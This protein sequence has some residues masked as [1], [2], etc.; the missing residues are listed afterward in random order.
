MI[1]TLTVDQ[2]SRYREKSTIA[3][4]AILVSLEARALE[5]RIVFTSSHVAVSPQVC[6]AY[7]QVTWWLG[8]EIA[9]YVA[10]G[11]EEIAT[12]MRRRAAPQEQ[13]ADTKE[14][15]L[16]VARVLDATKEDMCDTASEWDAV[17]KARQAYQ[18]A[19]EGRDALRAAWWEAL[20]ESLAVESCRRV[21][22]ALSAT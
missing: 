18:D 8:R 11:D 15:S 20:D 9:L 19:T 22:L 12:A 17:V 14:L 4:R 7:A 16:Y 1:P 5:E 21:L 10:L 3:A 13:D 2:R 6:S